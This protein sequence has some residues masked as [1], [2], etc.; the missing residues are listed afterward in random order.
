M[1]P[2]TI[3]AARAVRAI[4]C[5]LSSSRVLVRSLVRRQS[6]VKPSDPPVRKQT[7]ATMISLRF[8]RLAE[9]RTPDVVYYGEEG[10]TS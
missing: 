7:V 8:T 4:R 9:E 5:R 6:D 3:P 1:T 10:S 2:F